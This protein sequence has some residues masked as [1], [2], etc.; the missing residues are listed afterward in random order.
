MNSIARRLRFENLELRRLLAAV[1]I[2]DDLSGDAGA[3][4]AAPVRIDS[5]AGVRGAEVHIRFDPAVLSLDTDDI[6][7]GTAWNG[8]TDTL[9]VANVDPVAGTV[10]VFISASAELPNVA[11]SLVVFGFN[12][13]DTAAV[14]TQS[15]ID[16][17]Q[18]RLNEGAV[19]VTPAPAAGADPTDG[20]VTVS[21]SGG[22]L[23]D[24]ISGTVYADTNN[25]NLPGELE[26][27]PGV[28][29]TLVNTSSG[30]TRDTTTGDD[31]KYEFIDVAAGNYRIVQTQPTAYAD[32][33]PNEIA[34]SLVEGQDLTNQNF[35]ELG[36]RPQFVPNRLFTTAVRPVGSPAW[37]RSLRA[38]NIAA[39]AAS[40]TE[41]ASLSTSDVLPTALRP[42]AALRPLISPASIDVSPMLATINP[43]ATQPE[44]EQPT[45]AIT[46]ASLFASGQPE[47]R[48]DD[49]GDTTARDAALAQSGLW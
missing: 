44:S 40:S 15:E 29:I 38:V 26:G 17:V 20:R 3:Q 25:D 37:V 24:R 47:I 46:L 48:R 42:T 8:A 30:A 4:I 12:I 49:A 9:V 32:G 27:I 19:P 34:V 41:V 23:A 31:G 1:S 18:V 33:G 16:L 45:P 6:T 10:V 11:G 43:A 5:A 36:L 35:R 22:G 21:D 13:R 2:P 7:A 28:K 14:G 39:A